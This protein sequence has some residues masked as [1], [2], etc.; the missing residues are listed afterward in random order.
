MKVIIQGIYRLTNVL[1][2]MQYIGSSVNIQWRKESYRNKNN[3]PAALKVKGIEP[4]DIKFELLAIYSGLTRQQ[5]I[6]LE[7]DY[8]LKHNT[9]HPVGYN[10]S[11]PVTSKPLIIDTSYLRS[12]RTK[13]TKPSYVEQVFK[14]IKVWPGVQLNHIIFSLR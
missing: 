12:E 6:R 13:Q 11:N 8:I 9:I 4:K 5:L 10:I 1:N 7:L 14:G 3:L 2:G